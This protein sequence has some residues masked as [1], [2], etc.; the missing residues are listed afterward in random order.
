LRRT[1]TAAK[2]NQT[3]VGEPGSVEKSR[4]S[5]RYGEVG[6]QRSAFKGV[7]SISSHVRRA[8]VVGDGANP[9]AFRV[10]QSN[11]LIDGVLPPF[12]PSG[13]LGGSPSWPVTR[14][15]RDIRSAF[16]HP[17]RKGF[18]T[19]VPVGSPSWTACKF[20]SHS[21]Q[22]QELRCFFFII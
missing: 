15:L 13:S 22:Q 20:D 9:V 8:M 1:W 6:A 19:G 2:M 7:S 12:L 5:N 17:S 3:E 4:A 14:N 11:Q 18:I 10:R 16:P 21:L